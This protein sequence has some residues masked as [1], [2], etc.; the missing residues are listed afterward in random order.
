M[1]A[2]EN[3]LV[4][5]LKIDK[6]IKRRTFDVLLFGHVRGLVINFPS[7]SQ[8]EAIKSFCKIYGIDDDDK[9]I[10]TYLKTY[11]RMVHEL[12]EMEKSNQ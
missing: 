8:A 1:V 2:D 5:P 9:N 6:F 4:N 12:I 3:N 7:I 11:L 10:N